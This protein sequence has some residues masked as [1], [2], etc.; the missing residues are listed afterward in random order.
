MSSWT[1]PFLCAI[2]DFRPDNTVL[3]IATHKEVQKS[4][5]NF[6][7]TCVS[8]FR[9]VFFFVFIVPINEEG[10]GQRTP[11]RITSHWGF[12]PIGHISPSLAKFKFFYFGRKA[13]MSSI[14]SRFRA[15]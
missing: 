7:G 5:V 15:L 3:A 12:R 9:R 8:G 10:L 13:V 4:G 14:P 1:S 11:F 2:Q 6:T